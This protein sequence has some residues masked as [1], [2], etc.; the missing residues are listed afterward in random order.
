V[1]YSRKTDLKASWGSPSQKI[2]EESVRL[3]EVAYAK[4]LRSEVTLEKV[5]RCWNPVHEE[6]GDKRK[7][8]R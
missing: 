7:Q 1:G 2:W 6:G 5:R 8:G 3:V 4:V